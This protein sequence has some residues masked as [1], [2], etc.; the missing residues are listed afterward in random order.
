MGEEWSASC[1]P[2]REGEW[3]DRVPALERRTIR[4][5]VSVTL[6]KTMF[7]AYESLV[8]KKFVK[9]ERL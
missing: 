7:P 8:A 3:K 1:S 6:S 5:V 9:T 2:W 4:V